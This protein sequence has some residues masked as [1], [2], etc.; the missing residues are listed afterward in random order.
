MLQG[1]GLANK[2]TYKPDALK[3]FERVEGGSGNSQW[4][5]RKADASERDVILPEDKLGE[6]EMKLLKKSP[7]IYEFLLRGEKF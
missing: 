3:N 5:L 4:E 6:N 7:K 1:P 2:G